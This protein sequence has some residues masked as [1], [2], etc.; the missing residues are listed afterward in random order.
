[1]ITAAISKAIGIPD[2]HYEKSGFTV[3]NLFEKVCTGPSCL[4]EFYFIDA[5]KTVDEANKLTTAAAHAAASAI[6]AY[7]K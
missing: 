6:I 3:P 5:I 1:M 4:I 2:E 7:L